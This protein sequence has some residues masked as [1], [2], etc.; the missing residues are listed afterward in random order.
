MRL[1]TGRCPL[2][3][4]VSGRDHARMGREGEEV[5]FG[6]L[7]G[8]DGAPGELPRPPQ[9][10]WW[11]ALERAFCSVTS[12]P[13]GRRLYGDPERGATL[14]QA[15]RAR[16]LLGDRPACLVSKRFPHA[17]TGDIPEP[18]WLEPTEFVET[19]ARI[20][21]RPRSAVQLFVHDG[22]RG[23]CVTVHRAIRERGGFEYHDPWPPGVD[24][25]PEGTF[26]ASGRNEAGVAAEPLGSRWFV[27]ASSLETVAYAAFVSRGAW[28]LEQGREYRALY[29]DLK[30][31]EFW[32]FF[33]LHEVE[34]S[35]SPDGLARIRLAP[36][37]FQDD[38]GIGL[39][40]E[41]DERVRVA[42]L[43][44][45]RSWLRAQPM[46]AADIAAS[47]V[48][49]L[50]P[51]SD[52]ADA[53]AVAALLRSVANREAATRLVQQDEDLAPI[54]LVFLGEHASAQRPLEFSTLSVVNEEF[55]GD[56]WLVIEVTTQ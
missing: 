6:G 17:R 43:T 34:K 21:E 56:L 41:A 1:R 12:T 49:A 29:S 16:G 10:E 9:P 8:S 7:G 18:A 3:N 48:R 55:G 36:G 45:R 54:A 20:L 5:R 31:S 35:E 38:V 39:E 15:W 2:T 25:W 28:A 24:P 44:Q 13:E 50:V 26:L 37:A 52:R 42:R 19:L 33:H 46:L 40:F 51:E 47:F 27:S 14:E 53:E 32:S 22:R 4:A 23:H 30:R 11:L